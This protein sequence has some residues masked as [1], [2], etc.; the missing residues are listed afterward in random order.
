M[1]EITDERILEMLG[2]K[3]FRYETI[4]DRL[5]M[6]LHDVDEDNEHGEITK[7]V[8]NGYEIA[9]YLE[10]AVNSERNMVLHIPEALAKEHGYDKDEML[11]DALANA[12]RETKVWFSSMENMLTGN[13]GEDPR[14]MGGVGRM[15]KMYTLTTD[16]NYNG[17]TALY[18]EGVQESISKLLN[19]DYYLLPS[20][21]HEWVIIPLCMNEE[22]EELALHDM[23]R[24]INST[25]VA[26]IDFLSNKVLKYDSKKGKLVIA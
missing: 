2:V 17:A 18:Y 16:K 11:K 4:K 12:E 3:D 19:G 14:K 23:V 13:Y 8:G 7:E 20:S 24:M 15:D 9:F 10:G 21:R 26:P 6:R 5:K 25:E 22:V 1:R